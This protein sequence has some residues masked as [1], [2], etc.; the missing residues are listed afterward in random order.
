MELKEVKESTILDE[1]LEDNKFSVELNAVFRKCLFYLYQTDPL[2]P[3]LPIIWKYV[4]T[5]FIIH[6]INDTH[7]IV[8]KMKIIHIW[9]SNHAINF[10]DSK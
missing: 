7:M 8:C 5:D 1:Q 10:V 3:L 9:Q 4:A 6:M 2:K